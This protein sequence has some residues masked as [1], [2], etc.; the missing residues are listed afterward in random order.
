M[1]WLL[2]LMLST[3]AMAQTTTDVEV[4]WDY[5]YL[6]QPDIPPV[7]FKV[8]MGETSTNLV[9]QG[10]SYSYT[11]ILR[12]V[13]LYQMRYFSVQACPQYYTTRFTCSELS[14]PLAAQVGC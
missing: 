14:E 1:R 10:T 8:Y 12:D 6:S 9:E 4:V 13:P 5:D 7:M 2:L 3:S 11:Y